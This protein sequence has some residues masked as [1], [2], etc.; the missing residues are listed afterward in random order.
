MTAKEYI[1]NALGDDGHPSP[2]PSSHEDDGD[3]SSKVVMCRNRSPPDKCN[4]WLKVNSFD[5]MRIWNTKVSHGRGRG[6]NTHG[7][8][9]VEIPLW[10]YTDEEERD[11]ALSQ[12][13]AT[14][15]MNERYLSA[16]DIRKMK[17]RNQQ[18]GKKDDD[19]DALCY[20]TMLRK[21]LD[22]AFSHWKHDRRSKIDLPRNVDFEEYL[23][24]YMRD[25][26]MVRTLC[27]PSCVSVPKVTHKEYAVALKNLK[28]MDAVLLTEHYAESLHLLEKL[29]GGG[30]QWTRFEMDVSGYRSATDALTEMNGKPK[31]LLAKLRAKH[32]WDDLLYAEGQSIF[33]STLSEHYK[34]H[35]SY[36]DE[37]DEDRDEDRVARARNVVRRDPLAES[38]AVPYE[39]ANGKGIETRYISDYA[40]LAP[41]FRQGVGAAQ[42]SDLRIKFPSLF[43]TDRGGYRILFNLRNDRI[44]EGYLVAA[45]VD[46][47]PS[48]RLEDIPVRPFDA[49]G[50]DT[51]VRPS[52]E[53]NELFNAKRGVT[54]LPTP[55]ARKNQKKRFTY[56][57]PEDA[58]VINSPDGKQAY[59]VF[60]CKNPEGRRRMAMIDYNN[61]PSHA[62]Y[63]DIRGHTLRKIEKNWSPFFISHNH[64]MSSINRPEGSKFSAG[65]DDGERLTDYVLHF[66]YMI[67]PTVV[68]ACPD[69]P[70]ALKEGREHVEC[71]VVKTKTN[72]I[73]A[74]GNDE[75]L[76]NIEKFD[77][78]IYLRGSSGMVEYRWP[79]YIG[80]VHSRIH[81]MSGPGQGSFWKPC[82]RSQ[83]MVMDVEQ[84]LPVHL[85]ES[86]RFSED[87]V[88]GLNRMHSED[89]YN[90]YATGLYNAGARWYIGIDFDDQHPVLGELTNLEEY[91]HRV[92]NQED[93]SA[94][95]YYGNGDGVRGVHFNNTYIHHMET[96][97]SVIHKLVYSMD[98][99]KTCSQ[100]RMRTAPVWARTQSKCGRTPKTELKW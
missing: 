49:E 23:N 31:S 86:L 100:K 29:C 98:S 35:V 88:K 60:N 40:T 9:E 77:K 43:V 70:S 33:S 92:I 37:E 8:F 62:L 90:H 52:S 25:N 6:K 15:V 78:N 19:D 4:P 73:V 67:G 99:S 68:L 50:E 55:F 36:E 66:V 97:P 24:T 87:F 13:Q 45:R 2:N 69:V 57:G 51:F 96:D 54:I 42:T 22:R 79:F 84:M 56:T 21:P 11:G 20:A 17:R 41:L 94:L 89:T 16:V 64:Y 30:K 5:R 59:I 12:T 14:F 82:Y 39:D 32:R 1:Q 71:E 74:S 10:L 46:I 93:T 80:L 47:D 75:S 83:M 34:T 95:T 72:N 7:A 91:F 44:C 53:R 61:D 81:M 28:A 3:V 27:G 85:S 65:L 76:M 18:S 26:L 38:G 48:T 58:R 63:L